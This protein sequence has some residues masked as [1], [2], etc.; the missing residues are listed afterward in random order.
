MRNSVTRQIRSLL[1]RL[2][3][4][5]GRRLVGLLLVVSLWI[6]WVYAPTWPIVTW[7]RPAGKPIQQ[8]LLSPNG[9]CFLALEHVMLGVSGPGFDSWRL[10]STADGRELAASNHPTGDWFDSGF[11]PDGS[12]LATQDKSGAITLRDTA[13]GRTRIEFLPPGGRSPDR[14]STMRRS[15]AVSPDGRVLA[16]ER[17][18]GWPRVV[19]LW[20]VA[21]GR[22]LA[23][24]D[25][26]GQP[27]VF[28][29][30][31]R[32]LAAGHLG[33]EGDPIK[34]KL[35]DVAS[36]RELARFGD[37]AFARPGGMAF[38]PDGRRLA[39]GLR[40]A[41]GI[42]G[43]RPKDVTIWDL[44]AGKVAVTLPIEA[45]TYE[46]PFWSDQPGLEF[47]PDG[48][49]LVARTAGTVL[50]WDLAADPPR[51]RDDLLSDT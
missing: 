4:P 49:F 11:A 22:A 1:L 2:S 12:W 3:G 6:G 13:D 47:S 45:P 41:G 23:T 43:P 27:F 21:T 5:I 17:D 38:S 35:W 18:N 25:R 46:V 39:A 40:W 7:R 29:P 16:A 50:F 8:V 28:A 36:G 51:C 24:L 26:A 20:D 31:G 15:F 30:D 37:A 34:L 42:P 48:R 33:E 19:Q 9:S 32:T 44:P 14:A 10:W